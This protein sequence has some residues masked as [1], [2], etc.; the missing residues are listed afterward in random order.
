MVPRISLSSLLSL[1]I[2]LMGLHAHAAAV[3]LAWDAS[4]GATGYKLYYAPSARSY[5]LIPYQTVLDVGPALTTTVQGL[6]EGTEYV[7]AATAY[8]VQGESLYST[9]VRYTPVA[10]V[11][12][13][14]RTPPI[15][16]LTNPGTGAR[17]KR[18]TTITLSAYASDDVEL[19]SVEFLV[20]GVRRCVVLTVPYACRWAVPAPRNRRYMLAARA[21]DTSGN[22]G[23]GAV[24]EVMAK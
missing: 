1:L 13:A 19:V 11:P 16:R 8:D 3:T 10:L 5:Q 18:N 2:L 21:T 23:H 20:D 9:E 24:V 15:V 17:V 7:F 22:V 6:T 4:Q 14:D 12:G